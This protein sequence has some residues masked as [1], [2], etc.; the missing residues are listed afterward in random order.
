MEGHG[1]LVFAGRHVV[2]GSPV[3]YVERM[4]DGLLLAVSDD[5]PG[6]KV[7]TA[8]DFDVICLG[9]LCEHWPEA[10]EALREAAVHGAWST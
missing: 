8:D 7:A 5:D 4:P 6:P 10:E 3:S 1:Q 9:C 2:A